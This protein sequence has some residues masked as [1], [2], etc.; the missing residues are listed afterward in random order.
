[1]KDIPTY[2]RQYSDS[3]WRK[4]SLR[5]HE[6]RGNVLRR[7]V[8]GALIGAILGMLI[9]TLV[10]SGALDVPGREQLYVLSDLAF[11]ALW[12]LLGVAAGM[13]VGIVRSALERS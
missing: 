8:F 7:A 1:M 3:P 2:R 11:H 12:V 4:L 6:R 10:F 5:H 9:G 13:L